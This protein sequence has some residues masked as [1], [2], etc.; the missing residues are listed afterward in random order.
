MAKTLV[1]VPTYNEMGNLPRLVDEIFRHCPDVNIL[2][3]D[4][5]SPDGTGQWCLERSAQEARLQ[6]LIRSDKLG[7]GTATLT[8]VQYAIDHGYDYLVTMDADFSHP[9]ACI[10][11]LIAGVRV[12]DGPSVDV[13]IGSRYVEGGAIEGWPLFRRVMSRM[14]NLYARL[15]LRL[16]IRDCSGAFRC[17]RVGSLARLDRG[18]F[19]A[20]GYALLEEMLWR[21]QRQGCRLGET[22]IVFV[23]RCEGSSKINL[24][25]AVTAVWVLLVLGIEEWLGVGKTQ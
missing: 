19:R 16:P 1:A 10:P 18:A 3:V 8:A 21:L 12:P 23:E 13:M 22:P 14:I 20:K 5:G 9:P 15:L 17:F 4:D 24:K 25:E 7:L 6:C 2:V 11:K